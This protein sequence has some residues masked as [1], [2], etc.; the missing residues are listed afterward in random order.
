MAAPL[1]GSKF[2]SPA[3]K[4]FQAR[5]SPDNKTLGDYPA[6]DA[7][8]TSFKNG[9]VAKIKDNP[10]YPGF[11]LAAKFPNETAD[12]TQQKI[13]IASGSAYSNFEDPYT[14]SAADSF[15][16]KYTLGVQKGI[17]AQEDAI[18]P[19]N[20]GPLV[21]ESATSRIASKDQNIKGQFPSQGVNV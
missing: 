2:E 10:K 7:D 4:A 15:L 8:P 3:A 12:L 6:A 20:L 11:S 5:K 16:D 1:F 9:W 19:E 18:F 14:K 13:N 21:A 17:I